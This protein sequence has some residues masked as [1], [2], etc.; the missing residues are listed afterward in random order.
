MTYVSADTT[1][2]IMGTGD[3]TCDGNGHHG[4]GNGHH[5]ARGDAPMD[6]TGNQY[7]GHG[8]HGNPGYYNETSCPNA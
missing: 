6:G 7:H 2:S 5:Y 8:Q 1:N 3:G 4:S